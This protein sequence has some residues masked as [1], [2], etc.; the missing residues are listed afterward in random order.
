MSGGALSCLVDSRVE[1]DE[2]LAFSGQGQPY[3]EKDRVR[4]RGVGERGR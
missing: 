1:G 3:V 4:R 2:S